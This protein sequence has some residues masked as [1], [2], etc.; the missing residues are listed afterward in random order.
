MKNDCRNSKFHFQM[1]FSLPSTSCL[2]KL[3]N[4]LRALFLKNRDFFC[5]S[6]IFLPSGPKPCGGNNADLPQGDKM[7]DQGKNLDKLIEEAEALMELEKPR[8]RKEGQSGFEFYRDSLTGHRT[9]KHK[10]RP[11]CRSPTLLSS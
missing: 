6:E 4:T 11:R 7:A 3:P 5:N 9:T 2:L 1:T 10:Y 8:K